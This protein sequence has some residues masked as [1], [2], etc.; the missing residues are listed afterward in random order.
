MFVNANQ[1]KVAPPPI[2]RSNSRPVLDMS[3]ATAAPS[4]PVPLLQPLNVP[5][6]IPHSTS[7]AR[8]T[9]IDMTPPQAS[10]PLMPSSTAMMKGQAIDWPGPGSRIASLLPPEHLG[11]PLVGQLQ[12]RDEYTPTHIASAQAYPYAS[13]NFWMGGTDQGLDLTLG[14]THDD[15]TVNPELMKRRHVW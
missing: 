4:Q 10:L 5:R 1:L 12:L 11:T 6:F 2:N 15:K 8:D 9:G 7:H 13:H 3:A 14:L